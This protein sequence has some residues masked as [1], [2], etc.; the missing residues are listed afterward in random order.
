MPI[1][2]LEEK[3]NMDDKIKDL[4]NEGLLEQTKYKG[5]QERISRFSP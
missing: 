2:N 1:C 3:K 5:Y 4:L